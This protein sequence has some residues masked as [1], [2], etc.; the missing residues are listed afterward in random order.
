MLLKK[1]TC[2]AEGL[3]MLMSIGRDV[4]LT[5]DQSDCSEFSEV[6]ALGMGM[7][8]LIAPA[9]SPDIAD[10]H[11]LCY[12]PL[13]TWIARSGPLQAA[14]VQRTSPE[15]VVARLAEVCPRTRFDIPCRMAPC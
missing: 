8:F 2:C 9:S 6:G 7:R 11:T 15:L 5:R 1:A 12:H 14:P 4:T 10:P 3:L 13:C